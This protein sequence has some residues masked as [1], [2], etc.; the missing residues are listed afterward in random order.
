VSVAVEPGQGTNLPEQ[1][2]AWW[3]GHRSRL[4]EAARTVIA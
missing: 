1:D 3:R 4:E 2:E